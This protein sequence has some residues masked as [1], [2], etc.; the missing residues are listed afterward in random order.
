[1]NDKIHLVIVDEHSHFRKALTTLLQQHGFVV[2]MDTAGGEAFYQAIQTVPIPDIAI[3][4]Y[5]TTNPST[6]EE[7][8]FI[9]QHYPTVRIVV[10]S[11]FD[12]HLPVEVFTQLGVAGLYIKSKM[13]GEQLITLLQ[14]IVE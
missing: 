13:N 9:H 7:I 5:K 11:L 6:I 10:S 1:M 8:R 14:R 2:T 4:N 3:V 12:A